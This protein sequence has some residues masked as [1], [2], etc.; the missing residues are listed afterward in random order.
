MKQSIQ[1]R[2]NNQIAKATTYN[3]LFDIVVSTSEE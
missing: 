2:M 1:E 3:T